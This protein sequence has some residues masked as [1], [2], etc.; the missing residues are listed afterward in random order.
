MTKIPDF[1]M[2]TNMVYGHSVQKLNPPK[3]E[4]THHWKLFLYSPDGEDLTRWIVKVEFQ[5]DESFNPPIRVCMTEPYKV[6]EDG[7]GEFDAKIL[8][9]PKCNANFELAHRIILGNNLGGSSSRSNSFVSF[10][11][12]KTTRVVIRNPPPI[13]YEGLTAAKFSWNKI[14]REKKNRPPKNFVSFEKASN[15]PLEKKLLS[16]INS[17]SKMIRAEISELSQVQAAQRARIMSIIEQIEQYDPNIADA[18]RLF[19]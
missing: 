6:E 18:C 19:L 8:V 3:A 4:K 2:Q 11:Q 1:V 7:W 9:Y 17:K 5:L 16:N 12:K 10:V 15:D 13:L 14:K